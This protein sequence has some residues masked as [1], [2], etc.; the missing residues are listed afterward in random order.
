MR[1]YSVV[2]VGVLFFLFLAGTALAQGGGQYL[3]V[4]PNNSASGALGGIELI[5]TQAH[6]TS[7]IRLPS[8]IADFNKLYC[9]A[10]APGRQ[11]TYYVGTY[12][13]ASVNI[14]RIVVDVAS[15]A[16]VSHRRLNSLPIAGGVAVLLL[17]EVVPD[18]LFYVLRTGI[19]YIDLR[20]GSNHL[21]VDLRPSQVALQGATINGQTL[22]VAA[23]T[24]ILSM[25]ILD[26]YR[27]VRVLTT[28]ASNVF[29]YI[30]GLSVDASGNLQSVK[31]DPW[32]G[33]HVDEVNTNTGQA[34]HFSSPPLA[35]ARSLFIDSSQ[36]KTLVGGSANLIT[37]Q[38]AEI[39]SRGQILS[40]FGSIAFPIVSITYVQ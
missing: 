37:S 8:N 22:Y 32:A 20:D 17:K 3:G 21:L 9:I 12:D 13:V 40:Q 1:K 36:G 2:L 16:V 25:N 27:S 23:G 5:D 31:V 14:Y 29:T 4:G 10:N 30:Q 18:I 39:D 26:M 33:V 11:N 35:G 19:G 24:T 7:S 28:L 34:S 6:T 38:I 15:R